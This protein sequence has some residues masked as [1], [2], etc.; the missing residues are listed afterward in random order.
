MPGFDHGDE[1]RDLT[2]G[3]TDADTIY[4]DDSTLD[5]ELL[6]SADE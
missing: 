6:D 2:F 3:G 4:G 5:A 1:G